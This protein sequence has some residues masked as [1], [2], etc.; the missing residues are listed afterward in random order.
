MAVGRTKSME[1]ITFKVFW[2]AGGFGMY[3][4]AAFTLTVLIAT[5]RFALQP[6]ERRIPFVR[7]MTAASLLSIVF[8]VTSD[9]ATVFLSV[10]RLTD[11]PAQQLQFILQ[12]SFESLTPAC[13]GFGLL[14][15]AWLAQAVGTWRLAQRIP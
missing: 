3:Q 15:L 13:L 11:K 7:A 2:Q 6:D 12:G 4:V 8:S 9:F 14:S 5:L 1:E 10:P